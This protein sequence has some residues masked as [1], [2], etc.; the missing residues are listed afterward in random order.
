[1]TKNYIIQDAYFKKA[2]QEGFRA[3]SIYKI[4]E[5]DEKFHLIK[6]EDHILDLGCAPGSWLQYFSKKTKGN[7]YGFDLQKIKP[8]SGV[9]NYVAD[10]FTD[11]FKILLQK[12]KIKKFDVITSD[13]APKTSGVF[14]L[15]QYASVELG[16]RVLD[17]LKLYLKP[18][19]KAVIKIFRG[20]D[21]NDFWIPAKKFFKLAKTFKPRACRDRSYEIYCIFK[22]IS[23]K[24]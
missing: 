19:G 15:D 9:K 4:K 16:L 13:M 8:L 3:R 6:K 21:F 14:D 17:L 7:I 18:N 11:E 1:M 12:E 24:F 22:N 20:E 23:D 5:I 2:K 10:V